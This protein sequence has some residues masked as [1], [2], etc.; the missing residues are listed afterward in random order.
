MLNQLK[1]E[2][3]TITIEDIKKVL[4]SQ[5]PDK[6]DKMI[7][8]NDFKR[9]DYY[10]AKYASKHSERTLINVSGPLYPKM[11]DSLNKIST[12]TA[13]VDDKAIWEN[14]FDFEDIAVSHGEEIET[15]TT[16]T[17]YNFPYQLK[18]D[19]LDVQDFYVLKNSVQNLGCGHCNEHK[20]VT[21]SS[22]RCQGRHEWSCEGCAGTGKTS[23]TSC[24]GAGWKKCNGRC[25]GSGKVKDRVKN[26]S[27][28]YS[29]KMVN[30]STCSGKGQIK[31]STCNTSGQVTCSKCRGTR[32]IVCE[33]CYGDKQRYGLMDCPVCHAQGRIMK[34]QFVTTDIK[35]LTAKN[36]DSQGA[37]LQIK[38]S[39]IEPLFESMPAMHETFRQYNSILTNVY[40]E[41]A[42][43]YS[44]H[45]MRELGLS[46][47]QFPFLMEESISYML[48]PCIEFKFRHVIT[49]TEHEGVIIN[50]WTNP[51][52]QFYSEA[53]EL[54]QS[55]GNIGKATKGFFSKMFKTKS[56]L[57]KEDRKVEMKLLIY[58]AKAD[59]KITD[60][61][62]VYLADQI[63]GLTEFT[64]SEKK[65]FF[66]LMDLIELPQLTNADLKFTSKDNANTVITKLEELAK[67]DG[68]M[69]E[70]ERQL[71]NSVKALLS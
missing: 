15:N 6:Y 13:V 29:E 27:G 21:C 44:N 19:K 48:V 54:K 65:D 23:C 68:E 7:L 47:N 36:I 32:T 50:F 4:Q 61:E 10:L 5:F 64:N 53:E 69:E 39:D 40:D 45:F 52:V 11:V 17:V 49:N 71:I 51:T 12:Y 58:L 34:L 57:A 35:D 67:S 33:R 56:F 14:Q 9:R 66:D 18:G 24:R 70:E 38:D 55:I 37:H 60:D 28:T 62:K 43:Q 1:K 30:C 22:S 8:S 31:C 20:Y 3:T 41:Y 63:Q 2:L 42:Q 16:N 46:K 59:G 26:A 25:N